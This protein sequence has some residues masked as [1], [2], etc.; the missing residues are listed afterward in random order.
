MRIWLVSS[1]SLPTKT[2]SILD[3]MV[4]SWYWIVLSKPCRC[5]LVGRKLTSFVCEDAIDPY[6]FYYIE[7]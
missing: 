1:E 5:V 7:L 4:S 6:G 3:N 2:V